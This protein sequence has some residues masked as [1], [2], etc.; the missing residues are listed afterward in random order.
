MKLL[1]HIGLNRTGSTALQEFLAKNRDALR[2]FG[3]FYPVGLGQSDRHHHIA[4]MST[5]DLAEL[6]RS[7]RKEMA[8]DETLVLSSEAFGAEGSSKYLALFEGF[9]VSTVVYVR[10]HIEYLKSWWAH[11]VAKE[12]KLFFLE[13][14]AWLNRKLSY[15]DLISGWPNCQILPH[16]GGES[17]SV[18]SDFLSRF[19][20]QALNLFTSEQVSTKYNASVGGNLL[21]F[22]LIANAVIP[23][24][25]KAQTAR[26]LQQLSPELGPSNQLPILNREFEEYLCEQFSADRTFLAQ[27][28]I[29]FSSKILRQ[30]VKFP[31]LQTLA[32]DFERSLTEANTRN[33]LVGRYFGAIAGII[34]LAL[35]E[36]KSTSEHEESI[37]GE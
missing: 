15:R 3:L 21:Y 17:G 4:Q 12:G 29:D 7:F 14:F 9:D 30:G 11:G 19:A 16:Q 25:H 24:Q 18:V 35:S 13:D 27:L 5:A 31:N 37:A 36:T 23:E 33:M 10:E 26:E 34:N 2:T 22:K 28:G 1:I 32:E 6:G 20:P 8:K